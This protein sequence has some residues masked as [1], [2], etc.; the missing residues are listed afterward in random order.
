MTE[1]FHINFHKSR[2]VYYSE[3][4]NFKIAQQTQLES[5]IRISS[6]KSFINKK[7]HK[8]DLNSSENPEDEEK[9]N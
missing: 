7:I 3:K 8:L 6:V 4:T 1:I 9:L 5:M 2:F